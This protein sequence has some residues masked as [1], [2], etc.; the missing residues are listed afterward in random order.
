MNQQELQK[1]AEKC[2]LKDPYYDVCPLC[3]YYGD[4]EPT[5]CC[6]FCTKYPTCVMGQNI[7]ETRCKRENEETAKREKV[8]Q[9]A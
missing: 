4:E 9:T 2:E 5:A 6:A 7:A 1:I 3:Y 8:P